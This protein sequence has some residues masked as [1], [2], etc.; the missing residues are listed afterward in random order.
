MFGW[1][2]CA[3]SIH[4]AVVFVSKLAGA[5]CFLFQ[6]R[7]NTDLSSCLFSPEMAADGFRNAQNRQKMIPVRAFLPE[8]IQNC[9]ILVC[10]EDTVIS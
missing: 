1:S 2:R 9:L 10:G 3:R 8:G 5:S 7:L 4:A 6:L